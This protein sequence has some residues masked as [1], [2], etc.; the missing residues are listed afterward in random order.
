ME[1]PCSQIIPCN[2]QHGLPCHH[3]AATRSIILNRECSEIEHN[4]SKFVYQ[5]LGTGITATTW[6]AN[7]SHCLSR[8]QNSWLVH[9]NAL[10]VHKAEADSLWRFSSEIQISNH[11]CPGIFYE[12][13]WMFK[14]SV[15]FAIKSLNLSESI[16]H[17]VLSASSFVNFRSD[18]SLP[19]F[20]SSSLNGPIEWTLISRCTQILSKAHL[21]VSRRTMTSKWRLAW[22][23]RIRL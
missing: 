5:C 7:T 8:R 17:N 9:R 13:Q 12:W 14:R 19:E 18:F 1:H 10:S 21:F 4:S 20:K 6:N 15:K 11:G 16:C 2:H 3:F 23:F 22:C